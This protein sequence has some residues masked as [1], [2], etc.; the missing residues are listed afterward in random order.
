MYYRCGHR[1]IWV[2]GNTLLPTL[3]S[4]YEWIQKSIGRWLQFLSNYN[5]SIKDTHV[6]VSLHYWM[7][8]L[9]CKLY[10]CLH[11]NLLKAPSLASALRWSFIV[12]WLNVLQRQTKQSHRRQNS[13]FIELKMQKDLIKLL[14]SW[15]DTFPVTNS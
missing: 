8:K 13:T 11:R 12:I 3:P 14:F 15:Q 9:T 10:H 2:A 4:T 1:Y 6:S 5:K 7:F